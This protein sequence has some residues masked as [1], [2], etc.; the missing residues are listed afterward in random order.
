[1]MLN[2]RI[3]WKLQLQAGGY[4]ALAIT[5]L[6]LYYCEIVP[7]SSEEDP[8]GFLVY[9]TYFYSKWIFKPSFVPMT[10]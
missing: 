7:K 9:L 2:F 5:A 4:L 10:D 8:A 6:A 3:L 1:M